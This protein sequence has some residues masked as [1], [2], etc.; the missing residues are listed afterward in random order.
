[1]VVLG[2]GTALAADVVVVGVGVRPETGWL[3][4]SGLALDR[5]IVVDEHLRAAPGVVAVGDVAAWW[6]RRYGSRMRVQHWDDATAGAAV[7]AASVLATGDPTALYTAPVHDPVPYF[8]SDQFGHKLQY[9][10]HHDPAATPIVREPADGKGWSAAW[11]DGDG[12]LAA[13]LAVDRPRD[14]LLARRAL[15]D[16]TDPDP[17]RLADPS[18]P[19]SEAWPAPAMKGSSDA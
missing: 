3:T 14:L 16:G 2:D 8:W 5:G 17:D 6:S 10:G 4:G 15:I 18:V 19:L 13:V 9:V 7:A 1:V 12:R 11:L